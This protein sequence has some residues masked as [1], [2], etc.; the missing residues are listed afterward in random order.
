MLEDVALLDLRDASGPEHSH[1]KSTAIET[2]GS[3]GSRRWR[4]RCGCTRVN[5]QP[6]SWRC[7]EHWGAIFMR[8]NPTKRCDAKSMV[9]VCMMSMQIWECPNFSNFNTSGSR[10]LKRMQM[11]AAKRHGTRSQRDIHCGQVVSHLCSIVIEP[12][13]LVSISK[14]TIGSLSP[15]L[16]G[17]VVKDSTPMPKSR[18]DLSSS[19]VGAQIHHWQA[20]S[21][22]RRRIAID[23]RIVRCVTPA[24]DGE[25]IQQ[26]TGVV[27]VHTDIKHQTTS[28]HINN[29]QV[30][31]HFTRFV[32]DVGCTARA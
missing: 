11:D 17:T 30:L 2:V 18:Y 27:P 31:T 7:E 9:S 14:P 4:G 12:S 15:T 13:H 28:S 10:W 16:Q 32:T 25:V 19:P 5:C 22:F 29:W 21:H 3:L 23:D 8:S 24:F 20:I 6:W 1:S 26:S